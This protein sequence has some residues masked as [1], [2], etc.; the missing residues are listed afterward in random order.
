MPAF[1]GL[2]VSQ[3]LQDLSFAVW[4]Q[5]LD[6]VVYLRPGSETPSTDLDSDVSDL[7][8]MSIADSGG[9]SHRQRLPMALRPEGLASMVSMEKPQNC[10]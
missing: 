9:H 2:C 3:C 8:H 5:S 6:F 1:S 10:G 4:D 7:L